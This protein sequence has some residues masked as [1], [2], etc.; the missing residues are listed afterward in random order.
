MTWSPGIPS[1]PCVCEVMA[2]RD[3]RC[4]FDDGQAWTWEQGEVRFAVFRNASE[5]PR[6]AK[7]LPNTAIVGE[8]RVVP[9]GVVLLGK[10]SPV[11]WREAFAGLMVR[12]RL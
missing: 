9:V 12:D 3:V 8:F 4:S 10:D 1:E 7:I 5:V 2:T 11:V 6:V